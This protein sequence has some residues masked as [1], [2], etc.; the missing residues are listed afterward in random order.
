MQYQHD[1]LC[2][3]SLNST[4]VREYDIRGIVG[5]TLFAQDAYYIGK[6]FGV[7]IK[8]RTG[9]NKVCI[10]YDG[11]LTSELF[12]EHLLKGLVESGIEVIHL[13]L[14][15]T[16][17]VYFAVHFLKAAGGIMITGSHNAPDY[18]GFKFTIE[19]RPF[20]GE[21]I[22]R[23]AEIIDQ[24]EYITPPVKGTVSYDYIT[25]LFNLYIEKLVSSYTGMREFRIAWDPGNGATGDIIEELCARLPGD[26][27]VIN[28]EIDGNFP[29]HH[30]DPTVSKNLEQL[31]RE[32]KAH[33]CDFGI[34]F[35]GDGDRIGIITSSGRIVTGDQLMMLFAQEILAENPNVTIVA[36]VKTSNTFFQFVE[37][38]GGKAIMHK[39]GH[40]FIKDKMAET[41]AVFGAEMSGHIFFA[42]KYYGFDDAIYASIRFINILS[43]QEEP[44]DDILKR[45]PI[46]YSSPEIRIDCAEER[47]FELVESM[48]AFLKEENIPY[49]DIDGIR[50]DSP[51]GWWLLRPSNTQASLVVR[52]E[53]NSADDLDKL[54]E[55]V[56]NYL[57]KFDLSVDLSEYKE[58]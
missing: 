31:S 49:N 17:M 7:M 24:G 28:S 32:I 16:P 40:S 35:D 45:L 21:D 54:Y 15:P 46:S 56:E 48:K 12:N 4:I 43:N 33:E 8:E 10:G 3:Y 55:L 51:Y 23:L 25:H 50:A 27:I 1:N 57:H 9:A 2:K 53:G 14:C 41:G 13:G 37:N 29:N 26:H 22:K 52:C 20:Y 58:Q 44:I 47:K 19:G 38:M 18:N 6:A 30:P 42:D 34:A 5:S 36:D 39:T 11:R